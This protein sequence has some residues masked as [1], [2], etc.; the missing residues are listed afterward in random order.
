VRIATPLPTIF[1]SMSRR[2]FF[3]FISPK[4][5]LPLPSTTGNDPAHRF[6]LFVKADYAAPEFTGD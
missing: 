5:R 2:G 6:L 3:S 1:E 4:T